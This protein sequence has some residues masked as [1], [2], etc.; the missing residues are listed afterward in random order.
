MMFLLL[1]IISDL[2]QLQEV[3][4]CEDVDRNRNP[5]P[6]GNII[7]SYPCAKSRVEFWPF[8]VMGD[9][10]WT[11]DDVGPAIKA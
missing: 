7:S 3:P 10:L 9:F 4:I 1:Q 8:V 6:T 11:F 5:P 2:F